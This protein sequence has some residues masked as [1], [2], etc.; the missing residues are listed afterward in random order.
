MSGKG[1]LTK[2]IDTVR[3]R[4]NR[5]T[6]E[7]LTLNIRIFTQ[8][9]L[10]DPKYS[11][12]ADK[13]LSAGMPYLIINRKTKTG[14]AA[15][16]QF[17]RLDPSGLPFDHETVVKLKPFVESLRR[18]IAITGKYDNG[19]LGDKQFNSLI[20]W[21]ARSYKFEGDVIKKQYDR[22]YEDYAKQ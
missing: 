9:E 1:W 4:L 11:S 20:H 16:T 3:V 6:N 5:A 18:V 7:G 19:T 21:F 2:L 13:K 10:A 22:P 8:K 15:T 14:E 17:V 12:I